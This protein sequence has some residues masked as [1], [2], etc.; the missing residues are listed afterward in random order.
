[1]KSEG[2]DTIEEGIHQ[3]EEKKEDATNVVA[4]SILFSSVHTMMKKRNKT[5]RTKKKMIWTFK[6]KKNGHAYC[7][8]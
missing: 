1:M 3:T 7:A 2:Y 4:K 5:I 6:N 8:E